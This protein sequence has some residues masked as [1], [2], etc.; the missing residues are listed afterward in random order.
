MVTD[1]TFK[2]PIYKTQVRIVV[3]DDIAKFAKENEIDDNLG[4]Y[5]AIVYEF[6]NYPKVPFDIVLLLPTDFQDGTLVHE[7]FHIT[8]AILRNVGVSFS[9][10]SEEAYAYLNEYLYKVIKNYIIKNKIE[11]REE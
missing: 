3:C 9:N 10:D 5:Y 6:Y 7:V 1:I 11:K 8:C 4:I 2:V